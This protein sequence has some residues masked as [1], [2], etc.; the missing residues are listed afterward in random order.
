MHSVKICN[1]IQVY[2]EEK[3]WP[4]LSAI[5]QE[6]KTKLFT[7][8]RHCR[9]TAVKRNMPEILLCFLWVHFVVTALC[10]KIKCPYICCVVGPSSQGTGAMVTKYTYCNQE[11]IIAKWKL[12]PPG[13]HVPEFPWNK[14][15]NH[16]K[17][18][19][20]VHVPAKIWNGHMPNTLA[21]PPCSVCM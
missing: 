16:R 2:L 20:I 8:K 9:P 6:L 13:K 5:R 15:T 17:P 12:W 4:Q 10:Y 21:D 3:L 11:E 19:T 14:W 7:T 1:V 18:I